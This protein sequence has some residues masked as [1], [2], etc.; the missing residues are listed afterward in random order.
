M[1]K[2]SSHV[3][4]QSSIMCVFGLLCALFWFCFLYSPFGVFQGR[5]FWSSSLQISPTSNQ[6]RIQESIPIPVVSHEPEN[7]ESESAVSPSKTPKVFPFMKA[8]RSIDN[9]SDPCSERYVYVHDL[10]SR[11]N[12]DMV[13]ECG[14]INRCFDMCKFT[15]NSGVG[16]PLE[17]TELG[18]FSDNGW[19][20]T[21]QFTL[22]VIFRNR[23]K[24]YECLTNDS[25]MAAAILRRNRDEW[26]VMNGKDHFLV[27]GRIT[28]DFRRLSNKDTDWGNKFLFLPASKNMSA[29]LIESSPFN[30]ND[31]AIPYPTYFH[32]SKDSDV[33]TWQNRMMKLD[34]KWLFCFAGAL[35]PGNPKSIRSL[36]IDQCKN[37]NSGKLLECGNDESKCHSPSNIMKMFQ[38]SVFCLQPPGDSYTRRSAF[39]SILAGCIPVFFHPASFYT[40]YTWHLPKK[41]TK[42][43]IFIPE[44]DIRRN[45]SIEQRLGQIDSKT[46]KMMRKEVVN[47]IPRLIYADPRS[48]LESLKDAFDLS[49][50]AVINKVTKLRRDLVAGRRNNGGFI[51]ELSW[52]YALLEEEDEETVGVHEWDPFFSKPKHQT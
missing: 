9:K 6:S 8:L 18:V 27:G 34:R 2:G 10:P 29:L 47:L 23:M 38:R 33:F 26:K 41:Y 35:R 48:R 40:Q 12:E 46:V 5:T 31:F 50:E 16:P 17:N 44:G 39:D 1:A 7:V 22:D 4:Q 11:F 43:S 25:S 15:K 3:F 52:K 19:Y 21:N 42:Y 14:S 36:L 20:A 32:P 45:I 28:W 24:Q 51:E 30:S 49:V 13:K 37:S